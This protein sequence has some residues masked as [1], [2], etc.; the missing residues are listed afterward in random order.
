MLL[1]PEFTVKAA[2]QSAS[3][4]PPSAVAHQINYLNNNQNVQSKHLNCS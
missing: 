1:A 2:M 4:N 3:E